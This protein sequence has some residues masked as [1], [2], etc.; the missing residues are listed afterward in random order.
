M[1]DTKLF[2]KLYIY[3][4]KGKGEIFFLISLYNTYLISKLSS[5]NIEVFLMGLI[6]TLFIVSIIVGYI[7]AKY[8]TPT[9]QI[10]S[11]YAQDSILSGIYHKRGMICMCNGDYKEA[12]QYFEES[13]TLN[14]KWMDREYV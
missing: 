10:I 13:I 2:R 11:P 12:M 4:K 3:F 9:T 7:S 1:K 5:D 8:I 6:F 14:R